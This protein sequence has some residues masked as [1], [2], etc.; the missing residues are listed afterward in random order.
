MEPNEVHIHH[1]NPKLKSEQRNKVKNLIAVHQYCHD[2][3]H[4]DSMPENLSAQSLKRLAKY[5]K[6]L[7]QAQKAEVD[8][9]VE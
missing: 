9:T 2:L 8:K 7:P 6:A 4:S 5:R 1:V 3:I